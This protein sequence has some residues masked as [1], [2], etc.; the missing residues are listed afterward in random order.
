MFIPRGKTFEKTY[1]SWLDS[2]A[3]S[4][5][6]PIDRAEREGTGFLDIGSEF[7]LSKMLGILRLCCHLD[8]RTF[9]GSTS[10]G[11]ASC[12]ITNLPRFF[13][14]KIDLVLPAQ[15]LFPVWDRLPFRLE[16]GEVWVRDSE[17]DRLGALLFHLDFGVRSWLGSWL[18]SSLL[19]LFLILD[20]FLWRYPLKECSFVPLLW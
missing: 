15:D 10:S 20:H 3:E 4:K 6:F 14:P 16:P 1:Y 8:K 2:S 7:R 9:G 11:G 12:S 5:R 13:L 18:R 17:K 19:L